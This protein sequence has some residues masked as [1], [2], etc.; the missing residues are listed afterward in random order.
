MA[1]GARQLLTSMSSFGVSPELGLRRATSRWSCPVKCG[2]QARWFQ[3]A[4]P[5]GCL[6]QVWSWQ[7][8]GD[9]WCAEL[10]YG[11]GAEVASGHL[12][13]IVLL[14]QNGAHQA[15]HRAVVGED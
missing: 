8:F 3:S 2:L 7:R 6:D 10:G 9:W 11:L 13:F 5:L 4:C 15:H 12:P 14:G 1:S